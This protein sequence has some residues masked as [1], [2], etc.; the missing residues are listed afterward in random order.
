VVDE[1]GVLLA[2]DTPAGDALESLARDATQ[3]LDDVEGLGRQ[4]AA[5]DWGILVK[6]G[7]GDNV[8]LVSLGAARSL[9]V[10]LGGEASFGTVRLRVKALYQ[11]LL[12]AAATL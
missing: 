10:V 5:P 7:M 6:A 3:Q 8:Y 12:L 11:D 1:D 4:L 2:S 9:G